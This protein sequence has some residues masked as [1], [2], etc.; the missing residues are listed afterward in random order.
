MLLATCYLPLATCYAL[1]VL[2]VATSHR[3]CRIDCQVA[4]QRRDAETLVRA[5]RKHLA[6]RGATVEYRH[7]AQ[8]Q[9]LCG[10]ETARLGPRPAGSPEASYQRR[11]VRQIVLQIVLQASSRLPQASASIANQPLGPRH[12]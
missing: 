9:R 1:T 7:A 5:G 11:N 10:G 3:L 2:R 8:P 12:R 4:E 6:L